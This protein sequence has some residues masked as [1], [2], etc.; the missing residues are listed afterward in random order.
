MFFFVCVRCRKSSWRTY[1]GVQG[2]FSVI[3]M[4][5]R[6]IIKEIFAKKNNILNAHQTGTIKLRCKN[7]FSLLWGC[8]VVLAGII[9][10]SLHTINV[11][12]MFLWHSLFKE[13]YTAELSILNL[14]LLFKFQRGFTNS[15]IC[16]KLRVNY[17][18]SILYEKFSYCRYCC[19]VPRQRLPSRSDIWLKRA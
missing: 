14:P 4:N 3:V 19:L 15:P 9:I 16:Y 5:V 1:C 12:F 8:R 6:R 18:D 13:E 7:W 17:R 2:I 10:S 11:P